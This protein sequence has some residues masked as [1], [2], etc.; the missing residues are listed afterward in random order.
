MKLT[1]AWL[2]DHLD[3]TAAL[4]EISA[5]LTRLG[6]EVEEVRDPAAAL[7]DFIVAEIVAAEQHPNADRLR[8]CSVNTGTDDLVQVVCGAPN[9][10]AGLKTVFAAPGVVIPATGQAL[11]VGQ[12]RGI[13]SRGMLCS[14]EELGLGGESAGILE[15]AADVV[16]GSPAAT[17]LAVDDPMVEIALTPNRGDCLG[18]RGIARDLA[19][20]GIGVFRDQMDL[21]PSSA[22]PAAVTASGVTA[23]IA[24]DAPCPA[25]ALQ[26]ITGVMNEPSPEWLQNRL[27]AIGLKPIST[28]V[29]VT[30]YIACDLGRPLHVFDADKVQ[31]DLHITLSTGGE[32]FAALNG[33][34]YTLP[35]GLL[36]IRDNSGVISLA[37]VIGGATTA[38][39]I[40][41]RSVL[42][43]SALF[44]S[45]LVARAGR[46]LGIL[47]D[48]RARFERGVDPALVLPG[49]A[50]AT[51]MICEMCGGTAAPVHLAGRIPSATRQIAF[52]FDL[53][54]TLGGV[55]LPEAT[56][57]QILTRLGFVCDGSTITVPSWRR[58]VEAAPD[59]VEE[60]L[61]VHGYDAIP[62]TPLPMAASTTATV[63]LSVS[64]AR[65]VKGAL[66]AAGWV[67]AVT[68]S[69]TDPD[70]AAQFG[71]GQGDLRV[72]NP[73]SRELAAMRPSVL[74]NL[75]LAARENS[76]KSISGHSLF[77]VGPVFHGLTP[78]GQETAATGIRWGT[79]PRH[80]AEAARP[81][82]VF[83]AKAA[84]LSVLAACGIDASAV[85]TTRDAPDWYHPGRSLALRLGKTVLGVAGELHPQVLQALDLPRPVIA[86]EVF[87]DR[88]PT[89]KTKSS[90][91]PVFRPSA[92]QPVERDFAF[93]VDAA[94]PAEEVL[95]AVRSADKS[96]IETASVFDIYSG[97]GVP[98]GKTSLA[99]SVR[100]APQ[101]R[102]LT[103]AEL[104][105]L[106]A[107][108]VAAVRSKT[109]GELR[110]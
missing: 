75:L 21:L 22:Q 110:G 25:F 26:R 89:P 100:I 72:Q 96:L 79:T 86:F 99:L 45:A 50:V 30:N 71:G 14:A 101:D 39:D 9:A 58:D 13:E 57:R 52:D 95:K 83:D 1:L 15:L 47:T 6:L 42:V 2:K 77:E 11:K 56:S 55:S 29:D 76:A 80:W 73:I 68:W 37:G 33:E 94:T 91:R 108:I 103:E 64:R 20:A 44:D 32:S 105:E 48:A 24:P 107:R 41:T 66:A 38:C 85:Q 53:V 67:E 4:D 104:G 40:T 51:Q 78:A 102:T 5:T 46:A 82:D 81:W 61:R 54:A 10:W 63:P 35:A 69:F 18:V 70:L 87:L 62:A 12:I 27:K 28:L 92:F 74:P 98:E 59:L 88:L 43:E 17:A 97:K 19:A 109:G 8:V 36:V 90:A 3:T 7:R 65:T 84:A 23:T 49:L 106:S 93:L 34:T 60:I 16:P 31:G